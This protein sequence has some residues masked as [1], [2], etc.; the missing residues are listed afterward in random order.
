MASFEAT[1]PSR[2]TADDTFG[3]LAVFSNAKDWDPGVLDA[4]RLD[5]GRVQAGS[6]FRLIVPFAGRKLALTY[7]V[8]SI[9]AEDRR[10]WLLAR[11]GLIRASDQ[12]AV[13][14]ETPLVNEAVV[15]Y[16]AEV[17]LRGPLGLFDP[18]LRRGFRQVGE[19][20]AAGLASALSKPRAVGPAQA[21]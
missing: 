16:R 3:Y 14:P 15:T 5:A 18:L 20:A 13:R 19:R 17:T 11:S 4:E 2:W 6:R 10:V 12:I 1:I 7:Q 21:P 9:S 8:V